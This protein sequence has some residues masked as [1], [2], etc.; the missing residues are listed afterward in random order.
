MP[1]HA[2]IARYVMKEKIM[3]GIRLR[4]MMSV[5]IFERKK[6]ETR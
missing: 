5:K 2:P 4:E 6:A 1:L 3:F